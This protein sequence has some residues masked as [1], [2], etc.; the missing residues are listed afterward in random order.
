[1]N[2]YKVSVIV[3]VYNV[4]VFL[5]RC[6]H[7][8]QNQTYSNIE[9]ILV[10]DGSTDNSAAIC[11]MYAEEDDRIKVIHKSNGGLSDARNVGLEKATGKYI[12]FVDS[13]DYVDSNFIM[14]LV[15]SCIRYNCKIGK[16]GMMPVFDDDGVN[17]IKDDSSVDD[18]LYTTEE[19]LQEINRINSGFSVCNKIFEKELFNE[20]RFPKGK[21][22]EDVAVIYKLVAKSGKIVDISENLYFYY[23]NPDSITKCKITSRRLDDFKFRLELFEF[24]MKNQ[25]VL[26]AKRNA[27]VV[28]RMILEYQEKNSDEFQNYNEFMTKLKKIKRNL[29]WKMFFRLPISIKEKI[30]YGYQ[31][32]IQ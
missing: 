13:D 6:V 27:E 14:R 3:P 23:H 19:Y 30:Y 10:N 25:W 9:I 11:D 4:E 20:I 31:L 17:N 21:L 29:Y 16:I 12:S 15:S 26:A 24:C 1:M 18:K 28:Y 8:L 2:E 7:S 32:L 22:H 5:K